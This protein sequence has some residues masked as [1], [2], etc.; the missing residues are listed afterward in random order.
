MYGQSAGHV[1]SMMPSGGQYAPQHSQTVDAGYYEASTRGATSPGAVAYPGHPYYTPHPTTG[2]LGIAGDDQSHAPVLGLDISIADVENQL[3]RLYNIPPNRHVDLNAIPDPPGPPFTQIA[4]T[5]FAIWSSQ[6][7]RLTQAEI[8]SR[9]EQ[10]FQSVRD[11][12]TTKKW[13][14][15]IRHLLSLKKTFVKLPE[16]RNGAHY[17]SLDYR[18]LES[19]GDKRVRKRGPPRKNRDASDARRQQQ[20]DDDED[21]TEVFQGDSYLRAESSSSSSSP[22]SGTGSG[23]LSYYERVPYGSHGRSSAHPFNPSHQAAFPQRMSS[24]GSP[25]IPSAERYALASHAPHRQSYRNQTYP[26]A[27]SLE[28]VFGQSS[29]LPNHQYSNFR[30]YHH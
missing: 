21:D 30:E 8:W 24:G 28:P 15:N 9:I 19:G 11:P 16:S 18:Y 26:P 4:I 12:E 1:A 14:A 22:S 13:K 10:R 17:W 3:R 20:S 7:R 23:P 25:Y 29:F 27:H 6:Y 5:Q 2:A